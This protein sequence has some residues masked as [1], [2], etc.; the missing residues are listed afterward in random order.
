MTSTDACEEVVWLKHLCSN[1]GYD[2]RRIIVF[3]DSQSAICLA[4]KPTFHVR[5]K[6]IDLQY[7]FVHDMV[8]DGKVNLGKVDTRENVID[9]LTKPANTSKFKWCTNFMGLN[10]PNSC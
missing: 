6:H 2:A 7:H 4:K 10:T 8:E 3:C 1:I 5:T 9:P